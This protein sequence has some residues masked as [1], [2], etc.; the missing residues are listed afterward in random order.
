MV[1]GTSN[2]GLTRPKD[3][4][5]IRLIDSANSKTL[6]RWGRRKFD[7]RFPYPENYSEGRP[8]IYIVHGRN[9]EFF[10]IPDAAY[11]LHIRYPQWPEEMSTGSSTS[12]YEYKDQLIITSGIL[13]GYLH[14]EE[15]KDV[16]V[17]AARFLG[18][19][20]EAIKAEGDMDWE[21]EAEEFSYGRGGHLSGEPWLDP[22][23]DSND[24][25]SG[26]E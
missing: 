16:E 18:Q 2:L 6:R 20:A 3:I 7:R 24:P 4:E 10:R 9:V 14:F 23:G 21:P 19:M 11:T 25:L 15:Y 26:Y 8:S 17:W 5:S 12:V 22:Y 1:T 13:E